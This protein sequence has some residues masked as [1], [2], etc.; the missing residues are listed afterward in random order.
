MNVQDY[1]RKQLSAATEK[2]I[3]A[4]YYST[5]EDLIKTSDVICLNSPLAP[6]IRG[7]VGAKEFAKMKDGVIIPTRPVAS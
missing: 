7:L 1:H 5:I 3:S 6:E 4:K 2:D